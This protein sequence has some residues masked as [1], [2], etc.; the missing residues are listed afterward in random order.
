MTLSFKDVLNATKP[1]TTTQR[2]WT[3]TEELDLCGFITNDITIAVDDDHAVV[4]GLTTKIKIT[5]IG[6]NVYIALGDQIMVSDNLKDL[7]DTACEM[8]LTS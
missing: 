4:Y 8:I 3:M 6:D 2:D 5:A 7:Y 1:Q